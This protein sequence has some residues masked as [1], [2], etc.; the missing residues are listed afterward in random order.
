[1]LWMLGGPPCGDLRGLRR[2][3]VVIVVIIDDTVTPEGMSSAFLNWG[4]QL[5]LQLR[6]VEQ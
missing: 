4:D 3:F 1:M 6:E 2:V 5:L